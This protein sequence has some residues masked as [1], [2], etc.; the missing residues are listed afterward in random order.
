MKRFLFLILCLINFSLFAQE[1][2]L[3]FNKNFYESEDHWVAFPPNEDENKYMYGFIYLDNSAGFTFHY[4]GSF[5]I[6]SNGK[7]TS[8]EKDK[9]SRII[10]RLEPNTRKMAIIP[11]SKLKELEVPK[12]PD[13]LENYK[14]D[15]TTETLVRKGYFLN[16]IGASTNALEPLLKAY[17]LNPHEKGLEFELS[18]AYNAAGEFKKAVE[19]LEIALKN[20]PKDHMFY[21]ELGY[22]YINMKKPLEAE[23]VYKKGILVSNDDFQKA[24]MAYNMAGVYYQSKEKSKFEEWAKQVKKFATPESQYAKNIALMENELK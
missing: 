14:S 2:L 12:I 17:K 8:D 24:E 9:N 23:K 6:D 13:W 4:E 21:R 22:S 10:R 5:S 19:V 18:Y 16:H 11:D 15:E 3:E 1:N 7:F 20:N